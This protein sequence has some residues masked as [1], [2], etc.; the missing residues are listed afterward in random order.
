MHFCI[1][2]QPSIVQ[3]TCE[4]LTLLRVEIGDGAALDASGVEADRPRWAGEVAEDPTEGVE[5]VEP[6]VPGEYDVGRSEE[7]TSELQSH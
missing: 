5:A 7:H 6:D 2:G 4:R 3:P 1:D